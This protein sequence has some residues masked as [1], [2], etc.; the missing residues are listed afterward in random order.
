[1]IVQTMMVA[2][3][4]AKGDGVV[5]TPNGPLHVPY[6]LPGETV[7]VEVSGNR[8]KLVEIIEAV[9]QRVD[10]ACRHFGT[11][12]GCS[13]QH[14]Q[15]N[16]YADWKRQILQNALQARGIGAEVDSLVPCD[17]STRRRAGFTVLESGKSIQLGFHRMRDN[18][19]VDIEM[20]PVLTA[21]ISGR[22]DG[23]RKLARLTGGSRK[24]ARML[25]TATETGLDVD[26]ERTVQL[27]ARTA[28]QTA[29]L[30][31]QN[32][33]A[34]LSSDGQVVMEV[35]KPLVMFGGV[36][37]TPP[38]GGF[39]QATIAAENTMSIL[40]AEHV[41]PARR[42]ADLF[43][44]CGTFA[45]RLAAK[46]AVHAVESHAGSVAA[47]DTAARKAEGLKPVTTEKR[48][49]FRRPLMP[50]ELKRFDALVFDP[51]RAGAEDQARMIAKSS[52]PRIAAVSCNPGTLARDLR[53]LIDG[54]YRLERVVPIDQFLW[55]HHVEA[56]ALLSLDR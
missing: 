21:Q 5:E 35:Q 16:H 8:A 22:L 49:L 18:R 26:L 56:V 23:L 53:T 28:P 24:P 45:L 46:S 55:S 54:G 13:L 15:T 7:S 31:S 3:L 48:D 42:I 43:S 1:M 33:I 37:V 19:L 27:T 10:P 51:P 50:A 34:R 12:G 4:G 20:C 44:G 30:L 41:L 38:P 39:L 2:A 47:L 14:L 25:V 9:P 29:D 36:A 11:C 32:G 52:V 6:V 40:I 17:P